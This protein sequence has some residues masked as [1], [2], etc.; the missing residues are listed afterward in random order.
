MD[1]PTARQRYLDNFNYIFERQ[2]ERAA[3]IERYQQVLPVL[4]LIFFELRKE[5]I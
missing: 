2:V 3:D 5:C 1:S 4:K